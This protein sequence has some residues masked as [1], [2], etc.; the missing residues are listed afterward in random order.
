MFVVL[1]HQSTLP[2][3]PWLNFLLKSCLMEPGLLRCTLSTAA[4][5]ESLNVRTIPFKMSELM[6]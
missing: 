3:S 5:F 1:K 6:V 4:L 2:A